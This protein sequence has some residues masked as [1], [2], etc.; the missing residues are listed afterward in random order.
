MTMQADNQI[1]CYTILDCWKLYI[2]I[3]SEVHVHTLSLSQ[4]DTIL[5]LSKTLARETMKT[6]PKIHNKQAL[7]LASPSLQQDCITHVSFRV[8]QQT[9]ELF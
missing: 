7:I 9:S 1:C 2:Y 8:K 5:E 3:R 4:V 6:P